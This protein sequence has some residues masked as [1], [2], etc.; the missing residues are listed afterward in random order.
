MSY[1][2]FP[3]GVPPHHPELNKGAPLIV[4]GNVLLPTLI[5]CEM[6]IA[7][8]HTWT[9]V[10]AAVVHIN[11]NEVDTYALHRVKFQFSFH[12]VKVTHMQFP[13]R[14]AFAGSVHKVQWQTLQKLELDLRSSFSPGKLYVTLS[15]VKKSTDLFL[16]YKPSDASCTGS[17]VH[18][19]TVTV[20]SPVLTGA[21]HISEL[22]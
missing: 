9:V 6:F 11:E 20:S 8:V 22:N 19:K 13:F 1:H 4:T 14:F 10:Q 12:G 3:T 17:A 7:K 18:K 16:S 2:F 5:N 15:P 21:A